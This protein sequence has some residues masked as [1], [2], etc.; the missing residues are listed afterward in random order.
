[1]KKACDMH[2]NTCTSNMH[3]HSIIHSP[4]HD[5]IVSGAVSER[6]GWPATHDTLSRTRGDPLLN[7]ATEMAQGALDIVDQNVVGRLQQGLGGGGK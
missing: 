3:L 4:E 6:V 1:M 7:E 2:V 5:N